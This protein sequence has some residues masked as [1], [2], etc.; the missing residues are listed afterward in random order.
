MAA[1]LTRAAAD[2][3]PCP[4]AQT[5]DQARRLKRLQRMV[6]ELMSERSHYRRQRDELRRRLQEPR[7]S[8]AAGPPLAAPPPPPAAHGLHTVN[9]GPAAAAAVQPAPLVHSRAASDASSAPGKS[10]APIAL[11][12]QSPALA[13][14]LTRQ[15]EWFWPFARCFWWGSGIYGGI[16]CCLGGSVASLGRKDQSNSIWSRHVPFCSRMIHQLIAVQHSTVVFVK[17][18]EFSGNW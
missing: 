3:W 9:P 2:V 15:T 16:S 13:V 10:A 6:H 7:G 4:Q 14:R 17:R 12:L 18:T 11:R 5:E 8:G 1:A